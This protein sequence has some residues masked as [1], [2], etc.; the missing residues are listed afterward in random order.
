MNKKYDRNSSIINSIIKI[1]DKI[2]QLTVS[3]VEYRYIIETYSFESGHETNKWI[4]KT[5]E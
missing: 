5:N 2:L 1:I 4:V 3:F